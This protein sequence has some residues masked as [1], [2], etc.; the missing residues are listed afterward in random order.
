MDVM[1]GHMCH[2]ALC[3]FNTRYTINF[4]VHYALRR[5]QITIMELEVGPGWNKADNSADSNKVALNDWLSTRIA[6]EGQKNKHQK[7]FFTTRP[8]IRLQPILSN[9]H[10]REGHLLLVGGVHIRRVRTLVT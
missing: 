9:G 8:Y 5:R 10:D 2:S 6:H 4:N 3:R 7:P 1:T